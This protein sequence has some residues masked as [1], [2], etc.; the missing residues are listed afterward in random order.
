MNKKIIPLLLLASTLFLSLFLQSCGSEEKKVSPPLTGALAFVAGTHPRFDPVISDLPFNTDLIFGKAATTDGTADVGA[1]SD[2]VRGALNVLDGFS[3]SAYFDVMIEG[4]VNPASVTPKTVFLIELNTGGKDALSPANVVGVVGAATYDTVVISLDGGT[5]NVIRIRPT[6]PLK[7]KT[8]YL[9]FLTN[10]IVD[11]QGQALT[12]SWTYNALRDVTYATLDSLL[13]VRKA[14]LGWETLASGF[15]A[16]VS[17]TTAPAAAEKLVLTYTFTTTDS[18]APLVA[19]ASP[20]VAIAKTIIDAAA[21]TTPAET[22]AAVA[23]AVGKVTQLEAGGLLSTPKERDLGISAMTGVDL[24]LLTNGALP[25]MVGKLYTGYIKLPYYQTAPGA[26]PFGAFLTRNWTP[27]VALAGL[28]GKTLPTDVNGSYNV[29]Y[30]YPFA[31]KTSDEVVPLQVTLPE[32]NFVPGYAGSANCGQI[33]AANGYPVVI[34]VHGI[35]SDRSSAIGLAHT[36]ASKCIA[37]VAIDL[38]MH[39]IPANSP[40]V[41]SLNIEKNTALAALYQAAAPHERHFNVAGPG[42]APAPMN[43]VTPGASDGSGAQYINLGYLANTRDNGR[44]GVVDLLNLNASLKGINSKFLAGLSVKFDLAKVYVVGV[45]L[46]GIISTN[47]TAVNQAAIANETKLGL[48][49]NLNPIRGL[50]TASAGTQVTQI[51]IRSPTFGPTIKAGLAANGVKDGT[52][53]FEKFIY[54]AQ[55]TVDSGDSVNFTQLLATLG[56]PVLVQQVKNDPVIPNSD[57][58]APL[59][60]TEAF[61]KL[62]GATALGVGETPL[63]LG[64]VRMN[65]GGHTSLLRPAETT[66][67]QLLVTGELQSQVVTFILGAGKVNVGG[68]APANIQQP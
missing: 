23:A 67:A 68:I 54:A 30:R 50:V 3:T 44:E 22:A 5:N 38:P 33:Y 34:Y 36:L 6:V 41:T 14:I 20:R 17:A 29:T 31:A 45:S 65:S 57:P 10:G 1:A 15:L 56:V 35:T 53:S 66:P 26:L 11:A 42:G 46:G 32:T 16:A 18:Q 52:S 39:G 43:F 60:G 58:A 4:S 48:P 37:T 55:S 25:G 2:S 27:D 8:K 62:L 51:I 9:V 7:S 13:P 59:M 21:P 63:G 28:L 61:A 24:G 49:V 19:M 47:F 40:Y 12:R 64:Y